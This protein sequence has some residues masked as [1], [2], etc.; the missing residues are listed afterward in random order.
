MP[1]PN[2]FVVAGYAHHIIQRGHGRDTVRDQIAAALGRK[3]TPPVRGRPR[4][5]ARGRTI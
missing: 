5:R 4:A 1:R 2:R 3:V